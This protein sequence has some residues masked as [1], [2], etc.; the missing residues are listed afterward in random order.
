[1]NLR[2]NSYVSMNMQVDRSASAR[3][4]ILRRPKREVSRGLYLPAVAIAGL[5]AWLSWRGWAV[6]G[7]AGVVM[8]ALTGWLLWPQRAGR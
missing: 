2:P 7:Q 6:L 8:P 1:M 4:E 3:A 5:V